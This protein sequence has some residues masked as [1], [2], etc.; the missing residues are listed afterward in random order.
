MAAGDHE[1]I[2][3]LLAGYVLQSLSG[4]DA[5]RADWLLA[6]HVPSCSRCR[7]ILVDFQAVTGDLAL[8]AQ[9]LEPPETLLPRLQPS[10][11]GQ[12]RAPGRSRRPPRARSRSWS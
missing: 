12:P 7:E 8:T 10:R 9:P 2:E 4:E 5:A 6:R 11:L 1:R 3:E